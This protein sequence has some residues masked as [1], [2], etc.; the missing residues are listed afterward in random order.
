MRAA[1][2]QADAL[3][4]AL[5]ARSQTLIEQ[6]IEPG[7]K[8]GDGATLVMVEGRLGRDRLLAGADG[9]TARRSGEQFSLAELDRIAEHEPARL[10]AN[11]L[12]RPVVESAVVPT[13]AYVAGPGELRYLELAAALY[14]PLGVPRQ[15]PV[16]RW[17]GLLIEPRITRTL[18]KLDLT[19]D[20][21]RGDGAALEQQLAR[22]LAP[23]G[24]EPAVE[25]A[26]AAIERVYETLTAEIRAIDPTLEKP[27]LSAM[28]H[29]VK[30]LTDLEKRVL[31]AVKRKQAEALAQLERVQAALQPGGAPQERKLGAAGFLARYGDGW[32]RELAEHVDAW[33]RHALEA[34]TP[35]P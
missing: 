21:A 2:E 31:Q 14:Q 6:G 19:I 1:L 9:F 5:V 27:A 24:F 10:S 15:L 23:P 32:V 20:D 11:V 33:Y 26:R 4:A 25:S 35:S 18:D 3:D 34:P 12:L 7:V 8:V 29:A 28:G 30:G 16:P 22:Q 13:V 17:S